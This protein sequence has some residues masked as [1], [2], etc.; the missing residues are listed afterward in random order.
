[1]VSLSG[2]DHDGLTMRGRPPLDPSTVLRV[3]GPSWGWIHAS[4]AGMTER[5]GEGE[6]DGLAVRPPARPFDPPKGTFS[7]LRVS[8]PAPKRCPRPYAAGWIPALGGRNDGEGEGKAISRSHLRGGKGNQERCSYG[9]GR[10]TSRACL[11][12]PLN[13]RPTWIASCTTCDSGAVRHPNRIGQEK[14]ELGCV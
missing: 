14:R 8:G 5:S 12:S 11:I 1:M 7:K 9:E 2:D 13:P 10:A 3:S 6:R 4:A